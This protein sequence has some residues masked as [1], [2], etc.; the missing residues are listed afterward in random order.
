M[1]VKIRLVLFVLDIEEDYS[2][3]KLENGKVTL[4]FLKDLMEHYKKEQKLHRKYA[5]KVRL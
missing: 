2:G 5:Y 3:P 1:Y 4:E